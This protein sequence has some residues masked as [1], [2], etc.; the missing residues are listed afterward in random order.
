[1]RGKRI[2]VIFI[3]IILWSNLIIRVELFKSVEI[4]EKERVSNKWVERRVMSLLVSLKKFLILFINV[5]RLYTC[6][7]SQNWYGK[8]I[9][10]VQKSTWKSFVH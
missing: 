1:M 2:L 3:I 10:G 4:P 8:E 5:Y 7:L 6:Y 9:V